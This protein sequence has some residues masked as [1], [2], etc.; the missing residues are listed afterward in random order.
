MGIQVQVPVRHYRGY[1][2]VVQVAPACRREGNPKPII[3]N[4]VPWRTGCYRYTGKVKCDL[5]RTSYQHSEVF[6]VM[7][8]QA[9]PLESS[10]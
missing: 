6:W 9:H 2:F 4:V 10:L 1:P 5:T 7:K 3:I 8:A